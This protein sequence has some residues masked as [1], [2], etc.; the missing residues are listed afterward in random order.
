MRLLLGIA[1]G[2]LLV[3]NLSAQ[4]TSCIEGDCENGYG[5]YKS[6]TSIYYGNFL[7]GEKHFWGCEDYESAKQLY[8]GNYSQGNRHLYGSY[9]YYDGDNDF[10]M[11]LY[12]RNNQLR[13]GFYIDASAAPGGAISMRR[14]EVKIE[15]VYSIQKNGT[16]CVAGNC[17]NGNGI[18][19]NDFGNIYEG[20]FFN[21]N[22]NGWGCYQ[23]LE[24]SDQYVTWVNCGMYENNRSKF[25]KYYFRTD[26]NGIVVTPSGTKKN[27]SNFYMGIFDG[28]LIEGIHTGDIADAEQQLKLQ[29]RYSSSAYGKPVKSGAQSE[30]DEKCITGNC[31]NDLDGFSVISNYSDSNWFGYEY[32]GSRV[33]SNLNGYGCQ[34]FP[35]HT[36]LVNQPELLGIEIVI[37]GNFV[38]GYPMYYVSSYI[39]DGSSVTDNFYFGLQNGFDRVGHGVVGAE[40]RKEGWLI[41]TADFNNNN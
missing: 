3:S 39:K 34:Y 31:K 27:T 22:W 40:N 36:N 4:E 24:D 19:I 29:F 8:C 21:G 30:T 32:I 28:S 16:G 20:S 37:C 10:F 6:A 35:K 9:Y 18:F 11:G 2:I 14:E 38:N 25:T 26:K 5:V 17:E 33:D 15:P 23:I 13:S 41:E 12:D 1:F 7:N